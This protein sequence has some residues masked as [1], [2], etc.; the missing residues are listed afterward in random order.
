MMERR[1]MGAAAGGGKRRGGGVKGRDIV[2]VE[3]WC[4][5]ALGWVV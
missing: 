2:R 3:Q 4:K 1:R 5:R